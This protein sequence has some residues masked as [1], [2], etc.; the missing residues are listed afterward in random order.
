V[1]LGR[2]ISHWVI[3]SI[4]PLHGVGLLLCFFLIGLVYHALLD[5]IALF[6]MLCIERLRE[7]ITSSLVVQVYPGA[8]LHSG[9]LTD[10]EN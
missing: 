5:C 1:H 6:A 7:R 10:D 9:T 3:F 8:E 2:Q 4:H